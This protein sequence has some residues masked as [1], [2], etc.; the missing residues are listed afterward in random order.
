MLIMAEHPELPGIER[1]GPAAVPSMRA[2]ILASLA[3]APLIVLAHLLYGFGF[4]RGLFTTLKRPLGG[5]VP[6]TLE[7]PA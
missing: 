4:W 6:V 1:E 7:R 5:S 3:A 2:V